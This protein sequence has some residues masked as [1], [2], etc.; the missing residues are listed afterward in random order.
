MLAAV[1]ADDAQRKAYEHYQAGSKA[2]VERRFDEAIAR[3][4]Q[5]VQ[6]DFKQVR[7]VRLL[8]LSYQL[9]GQLDAA[10][11]TFQ[12]A[13]TLAP[14]DGESWYYLGRVFYVRNFFDRA[15]EALQRSANLRP[16]TRGF[17]N[18]SR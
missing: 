5:S 6:L 16:R 2:F 18:V 17:G 7:V 9:A 8:G 12:R 3:L 14:N 15:L 1:F 4:N 11:T 10:E 13:T